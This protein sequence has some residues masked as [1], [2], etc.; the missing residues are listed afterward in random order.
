MLIAAKGG[1]K[2][3]RAR[4]RVAGEET[5]EGRRESAFFVSV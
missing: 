2:M 3:P 5:K 1:A 4:Q